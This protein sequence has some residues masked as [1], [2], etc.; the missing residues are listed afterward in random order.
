MVKRRQEEGTSRKTFISNITKL[1]KENQGVEF[2]VQQYTQ[3]PGSDPQERR[4]R[5]KEAR[6]MKKRK[7]GRSK[8]ESKI[9]KLFRG[10]Q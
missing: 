7:M 10:T 3:D 2:I 9:P 4:E 5:H 1:K 8:R 6:R